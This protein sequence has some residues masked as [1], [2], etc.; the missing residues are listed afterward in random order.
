MHRRRFLTALA[1]AGFGTPRVAHAIADSAA[2]Q[3]LMDNGGWGQAAPA[4]VQP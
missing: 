1:A 3:I 4:D 2:L